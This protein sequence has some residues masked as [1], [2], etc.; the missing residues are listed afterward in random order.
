MKKYLLSIVLLLTIALSAQTKDPDKIIEEVKKNFEKINDYQVDVKIKVDVQSLKVPDMIAKIYYKK[1][2]KVTIKSESFAL[3]P[4]EGMDLSPLSFFKNKYTAI[5]VKDEQLDG[6]NT[7]IIK[8]IPIENTDD[9]MLSTMWIDQKNDVIRKVETTTKGNGT[10]GIHM[11]YD[12]A[13]NKNLPSSVVFSFNVDGLNMPKK[14]DNNDPDDE[15]TKRMGKSTTGKVY[16]TY[17]NYIVNKG[18]D[19]SVFEKK[20]K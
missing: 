12:N 11:K 7:S 6:M 13:Q 3:L 19:D 9:V 5:Y 16:I 4:K 17:N 10:I 14:M 1:P 18:V 20:E 2:D 8:V 15:T